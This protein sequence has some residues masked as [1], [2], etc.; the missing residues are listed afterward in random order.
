MRRAMPW[1]IAPPSLQ[2]EPRRPA[3]RI[4][5]NV[6]T[7][8]LPA[9]LSFLVDPDL[10]AT[11]WRAE[12]AIRPAVITRKVNGGGNRTAHG[13]ETQQILASILRTAL[14]RGL[15]VDDLLTTLLCAP[16]PTVSGHLYPT[17]VSAN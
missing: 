17:S 9:L 15:D 4:H 5:A 16:T 7:V 14:Q 3:D 8:E 10:D 12:H 1:C 13:A 6:E 2:Y 11:N